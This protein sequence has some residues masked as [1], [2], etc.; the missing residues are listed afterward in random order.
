MRPGRVRQDRAAG[1]GRRPVAWLSLD[2]GDND[3]ARFWRHV[4]AA[5]ERA[6]PGISGRAGPLLGPPPSQ[7]YEGVVTV[8]VNELAHRRAAEQALLVLDD[9]HLISAQPVHAAVGFLIDHLP[10]GLRVVLATRSDPPLRLGRLRA[11]GELIE[12]R[13]G[14]L[15]FTEGEAAVLLRGAAG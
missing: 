11:R 14:G 12:L 1:G 2:E 10:P 3:P 15:R 4:A 7:S 8:L 5:L 9:Y 6:C 13:A